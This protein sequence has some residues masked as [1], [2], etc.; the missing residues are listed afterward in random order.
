MGS[1]KRLSQDTAQPRSR[2]GIQVGAGRLVPQ[3]AG[4]SVSQSAR[5]KRFDCVS[6][7][8]AHAEKDTKCRDYLGH[9]LA[10]WLAMHGRAALRN[11]R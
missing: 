4:E 8:N 9:R 3:S 2:T 1:A 5:A 6:Q 11:R 7:E 10:P